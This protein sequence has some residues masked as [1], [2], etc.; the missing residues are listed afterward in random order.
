MARSVNRV[1]RHNIPT[2]NVDAFDANKGRMSAAFQHT[3]FPPKVI[4]CW[5]VKP[6]EGVQGFSAIR[7][8]SNERG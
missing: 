2:T 5:N 7:T 8:F 3:N 6:S 4:E 1:Y